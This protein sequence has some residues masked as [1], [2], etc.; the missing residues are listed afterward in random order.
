MTDART[1]TYQWDDPLVTAQRGM[2]LSG[3]E[4][5]QAYVRGE[6]PPAPIA[7]TLNYRLVAV[8][9]GKAVFE[10]E[11][12]EYHYNPI[13]VVHGG[14]ASTLLDSALGCAVHTTLDKGFGY[15]TVQLNINLIRAITKETGLVRASAQ[16]IHAGRQMA[17]AEASLTDAGGKLLAHASTTCLVFPLELAGK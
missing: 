8:E 17:T 4:Y 13:G 5:M 14:Y 3:L 9:K 6:Y 1:R 16:V 10:G 11:P 12:Q 7:Q 15:T 2:Q